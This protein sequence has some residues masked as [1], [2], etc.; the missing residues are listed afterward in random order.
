MSEQKTSS[1]SSQASVK[2]VPR[3]RK[4]RQK[5]RALPPY[6][7][8]LLNDDD[9]SYEYVIQM[10]R[11]LF[12]HSEQMG[13]Q[14]ATQVDTQGRA[15]VKTTHRELAELKRDQIHAFGADEYVATSKGS[16]SAMIE[17]AE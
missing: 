1:T 13:Y 3:P 17:P 8:V 10:L 7:V 16:M 9:H 15:I 4:S 14:L 6:H 12:G 11:V 5:P 2:S